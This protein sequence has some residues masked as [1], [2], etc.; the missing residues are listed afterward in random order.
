MTGKQIF[1]IRGDAYHEF[2]DIPYGSVEECL[3][4][5]G[6]EVLLNTGQATCAVW[7]GQGRLTRDVTTW[8]Q[9]RKQVQDN[10]RVLGRN[11]DRAHGRSVRVPGPKG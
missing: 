3:G 11:E 9:L 6:L 7:W 1:T 2:F 4:D 10:R 5:P 8:K